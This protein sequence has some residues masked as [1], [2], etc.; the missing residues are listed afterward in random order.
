MKK[1]SYRRDLLLRWIKTS[2]FPC[3]NQTDPGGPKQGGKRC[4]RHKW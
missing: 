4:Q 1:Y 2:R 3:R